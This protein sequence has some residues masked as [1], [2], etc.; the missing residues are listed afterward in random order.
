MEGSGSLIL[1]VTSRTQTRQRRVVKR[2]VDNL[3]S[4]W[5]GV[6]ED[7][8]FT[9]TVDISAVV[10]CGSRADGCALGSHSGESCSDGGTD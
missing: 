3:V 1:S 10:F 7:I 5:D 9:V 2:A 4:R 8:G 6:G